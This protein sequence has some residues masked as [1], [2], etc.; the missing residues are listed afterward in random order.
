MSRQARPK[1][2]I[3]QQQ[4]EF[5]AVLETNL[6]IVTPACAEFGID[7]K[8]FYNWKNE[9]FVF[10]D[11]VAEMDNVTLD[12]A[13]HSLMARIKEK[14]DAAVIFFL[15]TKG[16]KRGYIER[17]EIISV[18][19]DDELISEAERRL[20]ARLAVANAATQES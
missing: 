16:K 10:A 1:N 12:F 11:A 13:E 17:Q 4:A 20:A 14:S 18:L 19:S 15:K 2:K 7:R 5:L 3:T 9:N 6:G 8:T